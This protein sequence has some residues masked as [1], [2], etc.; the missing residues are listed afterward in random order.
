M[1]IFLYI[2]MALVVGWLG[3]PTQI[4]FVGFFIL[5]LFASPLIA[6]LILM[7]SHRPTR[8]AP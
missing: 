8:A 2:F 4:G 7:I 3:R 5:A 1:L 6:L